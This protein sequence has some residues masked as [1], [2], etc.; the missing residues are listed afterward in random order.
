[1]TFSTLGVNGYVLT[2]NFSAFSSQPQANSYVEW[3]GRKEHSRG[4]R[5]VLLPHCHRYQPKVPGILYKSNDPP[6]THTQPPEPP[7]L[8]FVHS[9]PRTQGYYSIPSRWSIV[10]AASHHQQGGFALFPSCVKGSVCESTWDYD[11]IRP[12][13]ENLT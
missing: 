1:M 4:V 3:F 7:R 5:M 10:T 6:S 12:C 8:L 11:T 9:G 13:F 2:V